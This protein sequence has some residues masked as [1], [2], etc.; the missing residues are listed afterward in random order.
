MK[1]YSVY[2]SDTE[3]QE[4]VLIPQERSYIAGIFNVLWALYHRMWIVAGSTV[5]VNVIISVLVNSINSISFAYIAESSVILVYLLFASELR[6][7]SVKRQ[8][9]KLSDI[10]AASDVSEAEMKFYNRLEDWSIF[11]GNDNYS[12]DY[13]QEVKNTPIKTVNPW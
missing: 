3:G 1:I 7:F 13:N 10:I 9:Y 2:T 8:G 4:P 12:I 5:I 11:K 6:E